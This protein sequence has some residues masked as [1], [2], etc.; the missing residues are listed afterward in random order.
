MGKVT[1]LAGER[2]KQRANDIGDIL[3]DVVNMLPE[4]DSIAIVYKTKDRYINTC[5]AGS[6][7][8]EIAGLAACL[9]RAIQKDM[10]VEAENGEGS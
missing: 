9:T 1:V 10:T 3:D 8:L 4:L 6:S 2:D 5:W 7:S